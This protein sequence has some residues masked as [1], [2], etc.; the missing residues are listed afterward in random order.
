MGSKQMG[1]TLDRR[2]YFGLK[3]GRKAFFLH[4]IEKANR[5]EKEFWRN[6]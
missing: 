3:K 1:Q 2:V 4:K 6:K 5:E